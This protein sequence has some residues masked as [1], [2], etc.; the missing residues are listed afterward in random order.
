M[1]NRNYSISWTADDWDSCNPPAVRKVHPRTKAN[2]SQLLN[3][4][5]LCSSHP[6][7]KSESVPNGS[8]YT[9]IDNH[10]VEK[11]ACHMGRGQHQHRVN[12]SWTF[13]G[14]IRSSTT[15]FQHIE[16][17]V[18]KLSLPYVSFGW[19]HGRRTPFCETYS[20]PWFLTRTATAQVRE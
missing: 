6:S 8:R 19:K 10:P 2:I 13:L 3:C 1:F 16:A 14:K 4:W 7:R 18:Y 9:A 17:V 15:V 20:L 12:Y 5:I 11:S